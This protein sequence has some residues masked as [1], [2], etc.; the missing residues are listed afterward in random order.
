MFGI[1]IVQQNLR[2]QAQGIIGE[3]SISAV[4]DSVQADS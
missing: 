1:D 2:V 3:A 4:G